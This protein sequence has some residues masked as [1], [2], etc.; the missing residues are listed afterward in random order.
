M[1]E[2][3][4]RPRNGRLGTVEWTWPESVRRVV[5]VGCVANALPHSA[6]DGVVVRAGSSIR[7][8]EDERDGAKRRVPR[9]DP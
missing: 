3:S 8:I 6:V 4:V 9:V 2:R 7:C 1:V 5:V